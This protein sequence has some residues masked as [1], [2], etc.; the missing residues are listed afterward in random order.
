MGTNNF[1]ATDAFL[2][3]LREMSHITKIGQPSNGGSGAR[4]EYFYD[5]WIGGSRGYR[6]SR[7][8]SLHPNGEIIEGKSVQPD[9]EVYPSLKSLIG[10]E[11]NVLDKALDLLR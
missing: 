3:G 9:I 4:K 7:V 5:S 11:D 1:S 2:G 8:L 10:E 6:L